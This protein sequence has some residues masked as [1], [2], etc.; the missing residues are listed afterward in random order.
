MITTHAMFG[1]VL[2]RNA[3]CEGIDEVIDM[4]GVRE[5]LWLADSTWPRSWWLELSGETRKGSPTFAQAA[6]WAVR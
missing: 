5:D 4:Q 1:L 3:C 2:N 6:D